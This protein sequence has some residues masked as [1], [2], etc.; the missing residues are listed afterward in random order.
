MPYLIILPN[1]CRLL[2]WVARPQL[3]IPNNLPWDVILHIVENVPASHL[4]SFVLACKG[5]RAVAEPLL[6]RDINLSNCPRRSIHF[7]YSILNRPELGQHV[8]TFQASDSFPWIRPGR[9]DQ[10]SSR[11][12]GRPSNHDWISRAS[13]YPKIAENATQHFPNAKAISFYGVDPVESIPLLSNLSSLTDFRLVD[14]F[15]VPRTLVVLLD[16]LPLLKHLTLPGSE[17]PP[18]EA[19]ARVRPD[20]IPLLESLT[21][22]VDLAMQLV[23]GRPIRRLVILF[24]FRGRDAP[25]VHD[26]LEHVSRSSARIAELG[27]TIEWS[28]FES[29]VLD[30]LPAVARFLPDIEI[31]R[32]S[33]GFSA[34][35]PSIL[36]TFTITVSLRGLYA[37]PR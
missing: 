15:L 29:D 19:L 31:L 25:P 14:P 27:V 30:V 16:C 33:I 6:Y 20:Q 32:L 35:R 24:G 23:P 8:V 2:P 3:R 28:R 10:L 12:K 26:V 17:T 22:S 5:L 4:Y 7:L 11:L 13:D 36:R 37:C 9:L 1:I 18:T 34:E 21:C